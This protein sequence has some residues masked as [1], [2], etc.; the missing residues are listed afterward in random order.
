MSV[1]PGLLPGKKA[2]MS[3]AAAEAATVAALDAAGPDP[4]LDEVD[5]GEEVVLQSVETAPAAGAAATLDAPA[6]RGADQP[7]APAD[8]PAPAPA[9]VA[10]SAAQ[11]APVA[12][13]AVD[14]WSDTEDVEY[15][16]ADTGEKFVVRAPKTYAE[17]V[18]QG[19]IRRTYADRRLSSFGQNKAWITPLIEN[20]SFDRLA[21]HLKQI[22]ADNELQAGMAELLNRKAAG[23]PLRFAD[24]A[25]AEA[26][27]AG[28]AA[29]APAAAPATFFDE[30]AERNRLKAQGYDDYT[31]NAIVD[32]VKPITDTFGQ[33]F[34][35][36]DTEVR[37][38]REATQRQQQSAQTHQQQEAQRRFIGNT[39]RQQLMTWY[40]EEL[41]DQTPPDTWNQIEAYARN[42]GM[43][44]QMGFSVG[45]FT[46]AYARMRD[47][48]MVRIG[49][50]TLAPSAAVDAVAAADAAA[51]AAAAG[52]ANGVAAANAP[53]RGV[54]AAAAPTR[55]EVKVPR[56]R[57]DAH[58]GRNVPLTPTEQAQ[59]IERNTPKRQQA[60]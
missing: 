13:A 6:Q 58:T 41:N 9:A 22:F 47:T 32:S 15:E 12:A 56:F 30:A 20:G 3:V 49:S 42:S 31:I 33:R 18:K 53:A 14:L 51:R 5:D 25:A 11:A 37:T 38:M 26:A 28:A 43:L 27:A 55:V 23:L 48:G 35:A 2:P 7:A 54:G 17:K 50:R 8:Q 40:P 4:A 21:P 36:L 46:T 39:A 57:K 60:S 59:W 44:D 16:D 45:A 52:A 29:A 10:P 24:Q 34:T 1:V 19:Y